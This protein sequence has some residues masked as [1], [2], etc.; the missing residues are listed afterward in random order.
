MTDNVSSKRRSEI[1]ASV[2]QK[3]TKPEKLVR[4]FLHKRGLRYRL[5]VKELPGK[6]DL[7]FPKIRT[8]IMVNGCFWH[9]HESKTCKLARLPKSN[10]DF[11]KTKIEGNRS[12][13]N[14][15]KEVLES[16]GWHVTVV[17]E[18]QLSQKGFLENI[19]NSLLCAYKMNSAE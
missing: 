14:K 15:N 8:V 18:C 5:H 7:V 9:G 19:A 2:G 10:V 16:K 17:W 13:D 1:M 12:R 11:W 4:S 3:N 6:P